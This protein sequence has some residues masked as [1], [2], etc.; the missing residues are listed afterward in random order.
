[1]FISCNNN[2]CLIVLDIFMVINNIKCFLN[3]KFSWITELV[4]SVIII[5]TV[6]TVRILLYLTYEYT[7]A[8]C[9][10]CS[11]LNHNNIA[12]FNLYLIKYVCDCIIINSLKNF[13]LRCISWKPTVQIWSRFTVHY[14]PH[15]ILSIFILILKSIFIIRMN[16]YRK[17]LLCIYEFYKD[18]ESVLCLTFPA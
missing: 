8:Y 6:G 18:R 1:M 10:D 11:C 5:H 16:L 9:M 7:C 4:P 3:M 14:I 15:L 2:L 13:F 17:C 12:C